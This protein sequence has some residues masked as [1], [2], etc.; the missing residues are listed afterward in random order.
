M[1]FDDTMDSS[2]PD[3]PL[4]PAEPL[5]SEREKEMLVALLILGATA[6]ADKLK[7][8][9]TRWL[10]AV[11]AVRSPWNRFRSR[12]PGRRA[13]RAEQAAGQRPQP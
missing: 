2:P 12:E 7:P 9:V 8:H 10:A 6:A 1:V 13:T 5:L 11:P 4:A 3:T